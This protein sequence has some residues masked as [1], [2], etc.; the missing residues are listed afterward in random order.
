MDDL[1]DY[2]FYKEDMIHP[3]ET[4]IQYIAQKFSERYFSKETKDTIDAWSQ[5]RKAIDHKPFHL[6]SSAHQKFLI[7]TL[8]KLEA[9]KT[10]INVELEIQEIKNR[11]QSATMV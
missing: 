11:L 2:R 6:Q 4:A 8:K 5:L 1:R 3:N 9:I 7:E 10:K